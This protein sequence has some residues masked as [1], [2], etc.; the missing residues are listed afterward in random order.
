MN[1][2]DEVKGAKK[3]SVSLSGDLN[4]THQREALK[5]SINPLSQTVQEQMQPVTSIFAKIDK[6]ALKR[7][8]S[9]FPR[10][11]TDT[12]LLA[13]QT[14][15]LLTIKVIAFE[16][17]YKEAN[18][19]VPLP[20]FKSYFKHIM[21]EKNKKFFFE[22][23][24]ALDNTFII[25]AYPHEA[26]LF[27]VGVLYRLYLY[28]VLTRRLIEMSIA[29]R[30]ADL[31]DRFK[32]IEEEGKFRKARWIEL[33]KQAYDEIMNGSDENAKQRFRESCDKFIKIYLGLNAPKQVSL[34]E[35]ENDIK[36]PEI[37]LSTGFTLNQSDIHPLTQQ[38][39][40]EYI[41]FSDGVLSTLK[42]IIPPH[43]KS[44][45]YLPEVGKGYVLT[46][47][48]RECLSRQFSAKIETS[49]LRKRTAAYKFIHKSSRVLNKAHVVMDN[50]QCGITF[51][52][53]EGYVS[54]D[55]DPENIFKEI[56][57]E[58]ESYKEELIVIENCQLSDPEL[59][60]KFFEKVS[61]VLYHCL[62]SEQEAINEK[63][64]NTVKKIGFFEKGKLKIQRD[65]S[66]R[67]NKEKNLQDIN[68]WRKFHIIVEKIGAEHINII[69]ASFGKGVYSIP[70]ALL[71]NDETLA[72]LI[73]DQP[74]VS[75]MEKEKPRLV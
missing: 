38:S 59:T 58:Y 2:S 40:R 73:F 18:K 17:R 61:K 3:K 45:L 34:D 44:T 21:E 32:Y 37:P 43:K 7:L 36:F 24:Q 20:T 68:E 11:I 22:F 56:K 5:K 9:E 41:N 8:D 60:K 52:P 13:E 4:A 50:D 57:K 72:T 35:S 16:E 6:E 51:S 25:D 49:D 66:L 46:K 67:R 62:E 63:Y 30:E 55:A 74:T 26:S 1:Q 29:L 28:E 27:K 42:S 12:N 53:H 33:A 69:D 14:K 70:K 23:E 19:R 10:L 31:P 71:F 48:M 65:K 15:K 39:E 54:Y 47:F 64:K 75:D